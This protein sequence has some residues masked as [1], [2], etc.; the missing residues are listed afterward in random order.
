MVE[1]DGRILLVHVVD[2]LLLALLR[3]LVLA[4]E[5][6][7]LLLHQSTVR[8]LGQQSLDELLFTQSGVSIGVNPPDDA[9]QVLIRGLDSMLSQE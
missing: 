6:V 4:S 2:A 3:V 8:L 5:P 9:S 1:V 7:F